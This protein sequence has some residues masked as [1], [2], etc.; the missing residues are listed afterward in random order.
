MP[1]KILL[2]DKSITIQKVIE[3]LF[4]GKEYEVTCVSDGEAA[5][6][7]ATR[8]IPDVILADVD[9]PRIDGYSFALRLKQKPSLAQTP[10]ILMK[11]RDDVFD[12]A[13]A[14]EAGIVDHIAKPF[15]S[16]DLIGK[17]KKALTVA[18]PRPSE[19]KSV[20]PPRPA[21]TPAA[22]TAPKP[23]MPPDI[24]DIIQ[25]APERS[26]SDAKQ[27]AALSRGESEYEVEPVVEMVEPPIAHDAGTALPVGEKAVEEIRTGLG[28]AERPAEGQPAFTS[29][30]TLEAATEGAR[31]Y[32]P[33]QK[34]P[35]AATPTFFQEQT[36]P[37][38]AL[39]GIAE[40]TIARLAREVLERVAW[41]VIPD[42]AE[43]LIQEEI[44]RLKAGT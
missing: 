5:L 31:E 30:E 25:E 40:E 39:K 3:M 37:E 9:L 32:M 1:V 13:R 27:A 44:Q 19:P 24:F 16:Q 11:S 26:L 41:E 28:L 22:A 4:S 14:K 36:I 38:E 43:R 17:V 15:E 29:F 20:P 7:E 18:L 34:E 8:V 42:L 33:P 10:V 6:N 12:E 2:A 35:P 23:S 21:A